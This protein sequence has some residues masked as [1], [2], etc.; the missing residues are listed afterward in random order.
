[1]L[2][3]FLGSVQPGGAGGGTVADSAAGAG[4]RGI[5]LVA[6]GGQSVSTAPVAATQLAVL[7]M[8]PVARAI[9]RA[10]GGDGVQ[11]R[12]PLFTVRGWNGALASPVGDLTRILDEIHAASPAVPVVLV[13][14]SMGARAALRAAGHPAVI[15]VAGL[16]PWLPPGEPVDQLAGR[17]VLLAHGTG[18]RTTSPDGTWAY[19][20]RA[21]VT[22][23]LTAIEVSRGD[24]PMLRRARL[25]HAIAAEFTR[26]SFGLPG[27]T[28]RA[29][30]A[31]TAAARQAT[32]VTL[33]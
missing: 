23:D 5:V 14:H 12:R 27:G 24:H 31:I 16:A 3:D 15:A 9:R 6:H 33:T 32:T 13:G 11:V 28:G 2:A 18:D 4:P 20:E 8:I 26:V 7:R 21:R 22:C 1:V 30:A 10:T 25:W 29:A 17:R 19:A